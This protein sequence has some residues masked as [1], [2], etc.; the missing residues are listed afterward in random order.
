[1]FNVLHIQ[2][3]L[4]QADAQ[5]ND[6]DDDEH[7]QQGSAHDGRTHRSGPSHCGGENLTDIANQACN[8][9]GSSR[10]DSLLS[11]NNNLN[12]FADIAKQNKREQIEHGG[13]C[14]E[15]R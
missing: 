6:G 1:M 9:N 11:S 13:R 7:Q 4:E 8:S 2:Q 10:S 15:I 5:T 12:H 3:T 14:E